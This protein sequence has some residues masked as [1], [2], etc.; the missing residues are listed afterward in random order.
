MVSV[1]KYCNVDL[2]YDINV[3]IVIEMLHIFWRPCNSV[4]V[5][6]ILIVKCATK[7]IYRFVAEVLSVG[8]VEDNETSKLDD[9][10]ART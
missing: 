9:D 7:Y 5:V 10:M 3:V 1:C 8:I 6:E 2:S 4:R